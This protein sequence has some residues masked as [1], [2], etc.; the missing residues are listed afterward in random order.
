[1]EIQSAHASLYGQPGQLRLTLTGIRNKEQLAELIKRYIAGIAPAKGRHELIAVQPLP[2]SNRH[3]SSIANKEEASLS[4]RFVTPQAIST[5]D[6]VLVYALTDILQQRLL[7]VLRHNDGGGYVVN[8]NTD[9]GAG[10]GVVIQL[11]NTGPSKQCRGMIDKTVSIIK[12]LVANG[13]DAK[14]VTAAVERVEQNRQVQSAAG[15]AFEVGSRWAYSRDLSGIEFIP[16]KV[17]TRESLKTAASQWLTAKA[18]FLYA[19]GCPSGYD[20]EQFLAL[21]D[22]AL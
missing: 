17:L 22:Q 16:A 4:W 10:K 11:F 9:L 3:I 13:P 18:A 8:T 2:V 5:N 1:P 7:P 14:E 12:Q 15:R 6:K 20:N 19:D 21:W